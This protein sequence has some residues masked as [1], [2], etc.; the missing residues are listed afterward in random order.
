METRTLLYFR[1]IAGGKSYFDVAE[2]F[3]T[4]QSSVS[5]AIMRLEAE[6]EI[7]L[8]DRSRRSVTLTPEGRI[9]LDAVNQILPIAEKAR[10]DID[11]LRSKHV[12]TVGVMPQPNYMNLDMRIS[13]GLFLRRHREIDIQ[14]IGERFSDQLYENL[15]LGQVDMLISILFQITRDYCDYETVAENPM[16]ALLPESHPLAGMPE[17]DFASLYMEHVI[18]HSFSVRKALQESCNRIGRDM[19]PNLE[20]IP[21]QSGVGSSRISLINQIMVGR[22]ITFYFRNDLRELSLRHIACIP[23]INVPAFPVVLA[24]KK[25]RVFTPWQQQVW[26]YL[27]EEISTHPEW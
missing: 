23:V 22:G 26:D 19:L 25:G 1:E 2:D 20:M 15:L 17:L 10:E 27:R 14:L 13:S 3:H 21:K 11:A 7:S 9:V 16:F 4:T 5:K 18:L 8:F 12:V 24:R 6:L